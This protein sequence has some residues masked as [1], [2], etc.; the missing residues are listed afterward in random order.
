M[1]ELLIVLLSVAIFGA[2]PLIFVGYLVGV[3]QKRQLI[4]GVDIESLSDPEGFA[5]LLG[6]SISATGVGML[7]I[8]VLLYLN[9]VGFIGFTIA[10]L[11]VSFL[12]LP[13]F[14]YAKQKYA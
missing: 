5:R 2:I 11:F 12:P 3:K 13:C 8:G 1:N 6:H 7:I 4:N 14:F 10:L 9:I